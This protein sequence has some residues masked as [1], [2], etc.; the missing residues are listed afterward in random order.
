MADDV[1]IDSD[2]EPSRSG[3]IFHSSPVKFK[4][5]AGGLGSGKTRM[6]V[7]EVKT[8]LAENSGIRIYVM[9]KTMPSLRDS[10]LHEFLSQMP[11]ELGNFN[12]RLDNFDVV[13]GSK[14]MFRGLDEPTK[15]KST[16][17]SVVLLDEA[18]EFTFEDFKILNQR[19]R[20]QNKG[21]GKPFPLHM[22]L[23]LN[24][25]DEEHWIYHE[26]VKRASEYES[27][28]GLLVLNIPTL[29]NEKNLPPGYIQDATAGMTPAE[30]TR[31]IGGQW[32]TIVHG[33][34]VYGD[35]VRSELHFKKWNFREDMLLLRGWD[36]GFNHPACSFRLKDELGRKNIDF[37]MLGEKEFLPDFARRVIVKTQERYGKHVKIFD[38]CD[39]RG[40]DKKDSDKTSA[41]M[42]ADLGINAIGERGV[43]S[44]VEPGIQIIRKELSSLILGEPELTINPE[45]APKLKSAYL[46]RYSRGEDGSPRKDGLYDHLADA[47]R[48]IAYNDRSNS[49]VREAMQART[50]KTHQRRVNKYTGY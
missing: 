47:D 50:A 4:V 6:A 30:I 36:F 15:L 3:E 31:F 18:D 7:E 42:L 20:Q 41:D 33:K 23:V 48:Y 29:E 5:L 32:G 17:V 13:N 19:L 43:R 46:G 11:P 39:P 12:K 38:Y 26:F 2:Y 35:L 25:V 40:F 22:I 44:Y 49:A 14:C 9:R 1:F 24:P 8:L 34:A 10:T 28:G 27:K 45:D 16:E 21:K 37:E